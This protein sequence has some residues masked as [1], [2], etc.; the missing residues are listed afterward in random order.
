MSKKCPFTGKGPRTGNN[1][2]HSERAT[3]RVWNCNLQ[4]YTLNIDGV[5]TKVRMSTRAYRNLHKADKKQK[6]QAKEEPK[7]E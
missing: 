3:R 1:R 4:T 2:S 6:V 5:P 7:A